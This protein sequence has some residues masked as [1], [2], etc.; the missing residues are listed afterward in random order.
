I[1][2]AWLHERTILWH[3]AV[4]SGWI[5]DPDRKKM[6]KSKGNVVTPLHLLDEYTS[7]GVRYWAAG[8]RLGTDTAFDEKVLKV[9]KRLVT[10]IYNAGKFVLQ[11]EGPRAAVDVEL[12]RAFVQRLRDLV[13]QVTRS[14]DEFDYAHALQDTEA[15]FWR[16]FTDT[17]LELVKHRARDDAGG[18]AIAALRLG[19]DVLLRLFA[20]V[21][22]YVTEEVW[23]WAFAG[24]R[25]QPSIHGA[26]WPT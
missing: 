16:D 13:A 11:Q 6:S 9:G 20:P 3:H 4:I 22:P 7:D 5:L 1:A 23:S 2:K 19:L 12:D 18:S 15:F 10:K 14:L 24:E 8:A 26:P 17:Y 25:D 21:L